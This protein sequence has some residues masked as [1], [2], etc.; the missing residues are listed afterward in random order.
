VQR[1]V[2]LDTGVLGALTHPKLDG[3][4]ILAAQAHRFVREAGGVVV[5]TTNVGHLAR[6]AAAQQ[7]QEIT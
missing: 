7:W 6:F 3:D 5:A 4:V 1:V 2:L